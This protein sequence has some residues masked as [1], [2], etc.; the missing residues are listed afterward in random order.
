MDSISIVPDDFD[1][2]LSGP[3]TGV[4]PVVKL[5]PVP[6]S[7]EVNL[8]YPFS[9][10]GKMLRKVRIRLPS[11]GDIDDFSSGALPTLRDL[12][13][14]LTGLHPAVIKALVWEDSKAVHQV[15]RDVLPAFISERLDD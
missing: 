5:N 10:D 2:A 3:A 9:V 1:P 12:L 7:R 6:G 4:D 8:I 15:F 14:R 11:Q 13:S